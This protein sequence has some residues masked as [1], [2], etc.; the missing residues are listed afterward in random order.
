VVV[1]LLLLLNSLSS[2]ITMQG[3]GQHLASTLASTGVSVSQAHSTEGSSSRRGGNL[4]RAAVA[5]ASDQGQ[6]GL[7]ALDQLVEDL[8]LTNAALVSK[9]PE[10]CHTATCALHRWSFCK[11]G[12]CKYDRAA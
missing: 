6:G 3:E 8:L 10:V 5:D 4:L 1:V 7:P 11:L 2:P 12:G 9:G